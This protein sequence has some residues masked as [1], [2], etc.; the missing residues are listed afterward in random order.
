MKRFSLILVA[1]I[2]TW[3]PAIF[4]AVQTV[5]GA[6]P[7]ALNANGVADGAAFLGQGV[8]PSTLTVGNGQNINNNNN[9]SGVSSDSPGVGT[10]IFQ[11]TTGTSIV[12]GTVGAINS[13]GNIQGGLGSSD[14]TFNGVVSAATFNVT[15]NGTAL[16]NNTA[17]AALTFNTDGNLIIGGGA[18]FNGAVNNLAANNGTLTLNSGSTLNGAVGSAVGALKQVNVVGGNATINGALSATNFSLGTNTLHLTG[19]LALPVNTVINTTAISDTLFGNIFAAGENDNI[20]APVVTVNVDAT[21]ALLTPGTPLFVVSAGAGT[22]AVPI[23]VTSNSIRYSFIGNNLNGNITITPTLIPASSLTTNPA[24][25]S[26]GSVLDALVAIAAANPGSDLAFVEAQLNA[27]PTAAALADALLQ[28]SPASGLIG[29]GRESFNTTRQFQ[30]IWLE[31]LRYDRCLLQNWERCCDPCENRCCNP[32]EEECCEGPMIWADGFGYFGHQDTKAGFNGYNVNTWGTVVAVEMPLF[33]GLR[34][35]LGAGYAYTDLDERE[36]GDDT[37]IHNYQGTLYLSYDTNPWYIDGGFSFGWN[38]YDGARHVSF[39]GIDR[40]ASAEYNGQ[41]YSGFVTTG[42]QYFCNC[43]EI[44]PY[45]SLLYSHLHLDD[46]TETGADSL[47]LHVEKQNYNFWE[48]SLG[49]KVAYLFKTEC[50]AYIPELHTAWLY[51]F[52]GEGLNVDASFT[53]IGAAAGSFNNRGPGFDRNI[54]NIGGSI[55]CFANDDFS[56]QA[57]Y[58]YEKSSTYYDHQGLLELSYYY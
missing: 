17:N 9:A 18:I 22:S 47:N 37:D 3:C 15:G 28:I 44:T 51:D 50:G 8:T 13:M 58:D 52:N 1:L 2:T 45:A 35:G 32:C 24:A 34:V 5:S 41:E 40:T 6:A 14:V 31:H 57:V 12:N 54:W 23:T 25:S 26:T 7:I 46:Y 38:R 19:A 39:T 55:T 29:V 48:S 43:F 30:R 20:T 11:G 21:G 10:I 53:G 49:I 56:I 36:F 16:F 33:C 27:L 42:Y 4:A